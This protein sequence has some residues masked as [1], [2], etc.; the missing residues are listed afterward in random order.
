MKHAR[1][2]VLVAAAVSIGLLLSTFL[3][4]G[5]EPETHAAPSAS[6]RAPAPLP[7]GPAP[8]HAPASL[9]A[10]APSRAMRQ[11]FETAANYAAF[12]QDAMQ[13][14]GEGGRFYALMA[15]EKCREVLRAEVPPPR[16]GQPAARTV[17]IAGIRD[18]Q[19]RCA[20]VPQQFPD[21]A[22]MAAVLRRDNARI[23]DALFAERGFLLPASREASRSDLQRA[24]A[25][26]DPYLIAATLD[27]NLDFFAGEV[28]PEF[29]DGEEQGTLYLAM[30]AARCEIIGDCLH[31]YRGWLQCLA[32]GDCTDADYRRTIRAALPPDSRDLFDRTVP[33]L[34]QMSVARAK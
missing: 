27:A 3:R 22:L 19:Q 26:K 28:G 16:E 14:P 13:R 11:R 2:P 33:A 8:L 9:T 5:E 29:R 34:I 10:D 32:A 17:A 6:H 4:T 31:N 1:W 12:I 30:A 21:E 15:F 7:G 25:S 24:I 18:L 20:G 23:P